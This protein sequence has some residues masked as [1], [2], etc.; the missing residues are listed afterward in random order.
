M[1][2]LTSVMNG[3]KNILWHIE[4]NRGHTSLEEVERSLKNMLNDYEQIRK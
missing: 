2:Y 3:I 1:D 4:T